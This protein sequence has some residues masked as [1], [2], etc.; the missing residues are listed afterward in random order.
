MP[1]GPGF[2]VGRT[3]CLR[4]FGQ[5]VAGRVGL[6]GS[7]LGA[8]SALAPLDGDD[9]PLRIGEQL[10]LLADDGLVRGRRRGIGDRRAGSRS[11]GAAAAGAGAGTLLSVSFQKPPQ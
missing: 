2:S 10:L 8:Q 4:L 11:G 3:Q 7:V 6:P 5:G 9:L 1:R